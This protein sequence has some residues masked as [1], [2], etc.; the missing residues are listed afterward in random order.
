MTTYEVLNNPDY[1]KNTADYRKMISSTSTFAGTGQYASHFLSSQKRTWNALRTS[2]AGVMNMN[3]FGIPFTG[4]DV[5]GALEGYENQT[6]AEQ[7]EIC[8]RWYQLSSFYPMA[9]VN[10]D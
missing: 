1:N 2:I 7:H 6:A 9:R 5:C 3:M 4:A 8:A 10:R